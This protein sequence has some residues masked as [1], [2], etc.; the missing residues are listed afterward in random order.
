MEQKGELMGEKYGSPKESWL[1]HI[2]LKSIF[3]FFFYDQELFVSLSWNN[4]CAFP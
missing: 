2:K 3:I 4:K 1:K